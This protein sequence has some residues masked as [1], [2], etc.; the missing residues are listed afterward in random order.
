M[1]I[2]IIEV[3]Y[4]NRDNEARSRNRSCRGNAISI[5]YYDYVF[6]ALVIYYAKRMLRIAICGLSGSTILS[7]LSHLRHN[8]RGKKNY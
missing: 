7:T 5:T 4:C 3:L 6:V 2:F 1:R 8:F